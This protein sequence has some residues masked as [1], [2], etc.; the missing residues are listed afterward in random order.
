MVRRSLSFWA[1][2]PTSNGLPSL[3]VPDFAPRFQ[4]WGELGQGPLSVPS[5][6]AFR[7]PAPGRSKRPLG[8]PTPAGPLAQRSAEHRAMQVDV[9]A[10]VLT[11]GVE[12]RTHANLTI[13]PLGIAA[14]RL[15]RGPHTASNSS[16]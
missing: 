16:R 8:R 1:F 10:Q 3:N 7:R 11:G 2:P 12:N 5:S 6:W 9:P 13:E 15:Q 14:K 4:H